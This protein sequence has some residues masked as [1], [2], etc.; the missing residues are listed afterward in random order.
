M[1][2]ETGKGKP[3]GGRKDSQTC[4]V[5]LPQRLWGQAGLGF[6]PNKK[7]QRCGSRAVGFKSAVYN[8]RV[9]WG[10]CQAS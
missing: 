6:P 3:K 7:T 1:A 4:T 8:I 10:S 2:Q 5:G 9:T